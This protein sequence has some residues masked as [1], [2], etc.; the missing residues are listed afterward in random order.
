MK[1]RA[2]IQRGFATATALTLLAF[3]AVLLAAIGSWIGIDA[4]RTREAATETQLRQ[5]LLAGAV[6]AGEE[7]AAAGTTTVPLPANLT[8][9]AASVTIDIAMPSQGERTATIDASFA[10]RHAR[11]VVRFARRDG[12]W[13]L[14]SATVDPE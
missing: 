1:R 14:V 2:T 12:G 6:A 5:L 13:T 11:Q 7:T 3:V 4:R 9:D 10:A 8:D